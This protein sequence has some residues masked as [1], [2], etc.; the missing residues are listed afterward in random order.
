MRCFLFI[1]F[2]ITKRHHVTLLIVI[3]DHI[4]CGHFAANFV[5]N[6]LLVNY[7]LLLSII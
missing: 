7:K 2:R 6:E 1:N 5:L 4:K 3:D